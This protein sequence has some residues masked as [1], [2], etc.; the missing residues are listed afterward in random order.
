[1]P[2][3]RRVRAGDPKTGSGVNRLVQPKP[4]RRAWR[5][6]SR[7]TAIALTVPALLF[8]VHA[9][10]ATVDLALVLAVD[11]S[12][13]IDVEEVRLQ[14]EGYV[15]AIQHPRVLQ[16]IKGGRYGRIAVAYFEW[17]DA[18][19]Q[20]LIVDWMVVSDAESARRFANRLQTGLHLKGNFTSI[21]AALDFATR[22]IARIEFATARRII[23]ISGDGKNNNGL[24]VAPSRARALQQGITINGLAIQNAHNEFYGGLPPQN[25]DRYYRE[26]V[27]GGDGAF[28]IVVRKSE[29]FEEAVSRKM[30]REITLAPGNTAIMHRAGD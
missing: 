4:T 22:L 5:A 14:R 18:D 19:K 16:A 11:V 23:D 29:D 30:F 13:S 7:L 27:I 24:P 20:A 2:Y 10:A 21:S 28:V 17:A 25:I 15:S 3:L 9:K 6:L 8:A 26:H 1:M 12:D